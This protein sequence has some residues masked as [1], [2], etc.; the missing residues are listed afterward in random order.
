MLLLDEHRSLPSTRER[1]ETTRE[2]K[3]EKGVGV[4]L[5]ATIVPVAMADITSIGRAFFFSLSSTDRKKKKEL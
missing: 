2:K 4:P 3:R 1:R 5:A